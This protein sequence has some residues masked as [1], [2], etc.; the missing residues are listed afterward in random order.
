MRFLA[1]S[2]RAAASSTCRIAGKG[3]AM[4]GFA[5]SWE[6]V[7]GLCRSAATGKRLVGI[8]PVAVRLA[9]GGALGE[10][11]VIG[12][13]AQMRFLGALPV[14]EASPLRA[15]ILLP[16]EIGR[17]PDGLGEFRVL[18][19]DPPHQDNAGWGAELRRLAAGF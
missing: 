16:H 7:G 1:T 15:T 18:Q 14:L 17:S 3:E 10:P 13:L 19:H 2:S 5:S 12:D 9:L 8:Q 11:A 6:M 4:A